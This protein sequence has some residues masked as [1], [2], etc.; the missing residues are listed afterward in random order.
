MATYYRSEDRCMAVVFSV[1]LIICLTFSAPM[2]GDNFPSGS[3]GLSDSADSSGRAAFVLV[4]TAQEKFSQ[5]IETGS[6]RK[7]TISR[8]CVE[9]MNYDG[10]AGYTAILVRYVDDPGTGVRNEIMTVFPSGQYRLCRFEPE[11]FR[12]YGYELRQR[13]ASVYVTG[14]CCFMPDSP[15][16]EAVGP[17]GYFQFATCNPAGT[18]CLLVDTVITVYDFSSGDTST[19]AVSP[20]IAHNASDPSEVIGGIDLSGKYMEVKWVCSTAGTLILRDETG[21]TVRKIAIDLTGT[22]LD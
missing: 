15:G 4:D 14:I 6:G 18:H 13:G 2:A 3:I 10:P 17:D 21:K 8:L 1:G 5:T 22:L 20:A 16:G 7:Y 9:G 19:I 12:V 11:E